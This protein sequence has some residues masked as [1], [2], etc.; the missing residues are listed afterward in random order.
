MYTPPEE[1]GRGYASNLVAEVSARMLDERRRGVLPVHGPANPTSNAIYRRIGYE[2][3]AESSM[4]RFGDAGADAGQQRGVGGA[5]RDG[6][7][8]NAVSPGPHHA[9]ALPGELLQIGRV[10]E[11]VDA[12]LEL[13]VA[14]GQ[15]LGLP[16][17][18]D[19]VAALVDQGAQGC[20]RERQQDQRDDGEH[21]GA[22]GEPGVRRV[23]AGDLVPA[24][25][26]APRG[27]VASR[28]GRGR[29]ASPRGGRGRDR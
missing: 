19:E 26:A 23:A 12:R 13:G 25:R 28:V 24:G 20:H 16:F 15:L 3:V 5:P 6:T 9:E 18:L 22:S 10:G 11:P 29:R 4:I 7:I 17:Q 1:R 27:S 21:R 14:I 2:Q 8:T